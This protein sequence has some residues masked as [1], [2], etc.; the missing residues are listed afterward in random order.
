LND[1]IFRNKIRLN[2]YLRSAISKLIL[3]QILGVLLCDDFS[4]FNCKCIL[5]RQWLCCIFAH[6]TMSYPSGW[7]FIALVLWLTLFLWTLLLSYFFSRLFFN[8]GLIFDLLLDRVFKVGGVQILC[9]IFWIVYFTIFFRLLIFLILYLNFVLVSWN[10][11]FRLLMWYLFVVTKHIWFLLHL[12]LRICRS[13]WWSF[14]TDIFVWF[15]S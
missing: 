14:L 9:F 6:L 10:Q 12:D 15:I 5:C 4:F 11:I 3:T 8:L 7:V 1:A 2:C 13:N